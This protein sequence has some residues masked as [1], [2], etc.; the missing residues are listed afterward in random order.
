MIEVLCGGECLVLEVILCQGKDGK[1]NLVWQIGVGFFISYSFVY[2]I[3]LCYGL[4]DVVIVVVCEIGCLVVDL[5]GMMGCIVIGKVLLQNVFGLVIIVC[6]VNVLVKCGFDWFLQ[7][8]VLLLFSLCII[9]LLLILI[10]DGG[11]LLYY[12][13]ELVKGSL[14]SECVIVVG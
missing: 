14:L 12:F 11:Y 6:V 9:N 4:L 8:F 3:L 10:L 13:I 5:L 2:D 1:G 7:F